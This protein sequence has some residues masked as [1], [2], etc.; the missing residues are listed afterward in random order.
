[1][2]MYLSYHLHVIWYTKMYTVYK[3]SVLQISE[4]WTYFCLRIFNELCYAENLAMQSLYCPMVSNTWSIWP[5]AIPGKRP[6]WEWTCN[7]QESVVSESAA[8]CHGRNFQ[9]LMI[10]Q[11]NPVVRNKHLEYQQNGE[12][13]WLHHTVITV[14]VAILRRCHW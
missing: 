4:Y 13:L 3:S 2:A 9:P 11:F 7:I 5:I 14:R 10:I 8:L 12:E 6:A 1:M